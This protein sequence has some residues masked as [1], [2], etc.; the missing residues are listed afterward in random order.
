MVPLIGDGKRPVERLL[1]VARESWHLQ[2]HFHPTF[3][4]QGSA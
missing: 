2:F 3:H 1:E 4:D